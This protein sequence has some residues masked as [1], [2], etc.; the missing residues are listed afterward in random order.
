MDIIKIVKKIIS[1]SKK[2]SINNL[3]DI[4]SVDKYI[5]ELTEDY[6]FK[7]YGNCN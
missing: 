6:I 7:T 4:Y 5:R 2:H 3:E 1:I